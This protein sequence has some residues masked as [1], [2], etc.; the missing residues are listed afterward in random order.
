MIAQPA[1]TAQAQEPGGVI[2]H[3]QDRPPGPALSP[4]E[5]IA[6]MTVPDGFSVELVAGEPDI[7]NPVAMT[8]DEKGRVWITESLEYP[9]QKP[10]PGR[11][12]VKVLE[13]TDGDGKA[14]RFKVFIDGLNIPSGVAVGHGGVWVANSPDILFIPDTDGDLNPD[15]PPQVIVTGF[16]RDDTHE[17]PNSL[18]WGP[19]G[20]LYGWNG[21][22]NRSHIAHRGKSY[23]FTCA[24]FRIH[25]KTRDFEVFC[26]GTSNPWGIAINDNGDFFASACV[27]D[28]LWHLV[29]SA[30]YIRQGGPY[31]PFTWPMGSIVDHRHQKAAYCGI[32]YFDSPAYPEEFRGKLFMGNI[33]GNSINVD[34]LERN[35][36]SYRARVNA[37]FLSANDAWFMPVVQ[38]TGPDGCLYI[39]DW[40]DRYHCYQD[41]NRDPAGIDRLKGRL[42]RVRYK[43]TP[44]RA[45]F[46]LSKEP[47]ETLIPDL[48][49]P[50]VYDRDIAQRLLTERLLGGKAG[51]KTRAAL[52]SLVLADSASRKARMHGLWTLVSSGSL[53]PTFHLSLLKHP[54]ASFRA[55][56]VRAAG[57]MGKVQD[58]VRKHAASMAADS[59]PDVRLQ[60]AIAARKLEA[61]EPLTVLLDVLSKSRDPLMP[62]VVWQ[63][64]HPM[65]D[66]PATVAR[67]VGL[68]EGHDSVQSPQLAALMPRILDRVIAA[69][70]ADAGTMA[71]LISMALEQLGDEATHRACLDTLTDQVRQGRLKGDR[72]DA[73]RELLT[74]MAHK[75]LREGDSPLRKDYAELAAAW[76][77]NDALEV[78]RSQFA[79][80]EADEEDRLQ[81]LAVLISTRDAVVITEVARVLTDRTGS[82]DFRGRL[83]AALGPHDDARIAQVVLSIYAELEPVLKPKA[84]E[85]LTERPA[86]SLALI[87]A[88]E[89]RS[90]PTSALNVN[91][92]RRLQASKHRDI[93]EKVKALW[94]S[95]R[96]GR[97]ARREQVVGQMRNFLHKTSGDPAAGQAV[98]RKLCA[99]C[100]KIYGEGQ[101][102]GPD[103]TLN[104]RNDFNQLISNVFAP[105]LVIGQGYQATTVATTDGRVLSGLLAEDNN[106]RVILR[107]QGGKVETIPR[108]EVEEMKTSPLSL[109]PED[110]ET[111]LTPQEIADLFA[112]LALDKPPGDPSAKRLPGS[113]EAITG[114]R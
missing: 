71:R 78:V 61:V 91:Q 96:Q 104:G 10:G 45:G 103:I 101:D 109:M 43:D 54:D 30:Y 79:S 75:A 84:I 40:Y 113:P 11:D 28:H 47:D 42:Y 106:E 9:R 60:V 48:G 18:T 37:D 4:H 1:G 69:G 33:H 46:D 63:N 52:E 16:G 39:L 62:H 34:R 102:V 55:W 94:G 73:V 13:D 99:Q 58:D 56:G 32:H 41:A 8:F 51:S 86:W 66:E 74:P 20:W 12:R 59:S 22:F 88:V 67:L 89:A 15:G 110:V 111:Q 3:A 26:E 92:L 53:D 93:A 5:A 68:S 21:V 65:L 64:L 17:L 108:S 87:A 25:P 97:N 107:I 98:F 7:V 31:P 50:N 80:A 6:R 27:I 95:V 83:L 2:P 35:G 44:R 90:V 23:D 85:L 70:S 100:H 82:V 36:S 49:S 29:E 19:D 72:L 14:D 57:S 105:S 81:A 76:G 77:D 112:Y 114:A 24:I 38:K